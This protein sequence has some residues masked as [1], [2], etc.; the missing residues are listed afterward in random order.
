[1]RVGTKNILIIK[2][3]E[4]PV[5]WNGVPWDLF[6]YFAAGGEWLWMLIVK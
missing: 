4:V 6:I 1:M 3:C 5:N 2:Y